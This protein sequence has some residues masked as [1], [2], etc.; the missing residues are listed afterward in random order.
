M[1][2]FVRVC[3]KLHRKRASKVGILVE[4]VKTVATFERKQFEVDFAQNVLWELI[5]ETCALGAD[6]TACYRFPPKNLFVEPISFCKLHYL[7]HFLMI[8]MNLVEFANTSDASQMI[9]P[10]I[11]SFCL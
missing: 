2:E 5:T 6:V 3:F 9:R 7:F 4:T 11:V 1:S 10:I 8:S